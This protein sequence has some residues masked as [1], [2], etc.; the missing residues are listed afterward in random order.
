MRGTPLPPFPGR[1]RELDGV[2]VAN[3]RHT[4]RLKGVL[5][6]SLAGTTLGYLLFAA[7]V[8]AVAS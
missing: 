5:G 4:S 7:A 2:H 6:W 1:F 8:G 3:H